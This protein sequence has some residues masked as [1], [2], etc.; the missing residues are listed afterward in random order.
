M[1]VAGVLFYG[2]QS[3]Q[4][5]QYGYKIEAAQQAKAQLVEKGNRLRV[6]REQ[7]ENPTRIE[8]MAK[9]MGMVPFAPGQLVSVNLDTREN[10]ELQLSAKK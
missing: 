10:T 1:F 6:T 4:Y 9:D 7:L 8:S 2:W 5:N 3:A